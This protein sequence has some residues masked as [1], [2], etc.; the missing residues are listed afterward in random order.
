MSLP[1]APFAS[2]RPAVIVTMTFHIT[3]DQQAVLARVHGCESYEVG[4]VLLD[5]F[6]RQAVTDAFSRVAMKTRVAASTTM[7]ITKKR[8]P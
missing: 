8:K 7:T 4:T 1:P 6:I 5:P 2:W 3:L